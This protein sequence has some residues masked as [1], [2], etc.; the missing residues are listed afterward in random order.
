MTDSLPPVLLVIEDS[1]EDFIA[2]ERILL[3]SEVNCRL[4]RST[5][6][7]EALRFLLQ[8]GEYAN[9]KLAPRPSL[10]LLDLTLPGT[11]GKDILKQLK[12]QENLRSIPVIA[13]SSSNHSK[14][15]ESLYQLGVNSYILKPINTAKFKTTM[16]LLVEY[17]FIASTLPKSETEQ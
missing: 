7:D 6:G 17:W 15:I 16:Q 12:Q 14:E 3:Q 1:D 10:I 11:D 5:T 2:F 8:Q 13:V 4:Y 9:P